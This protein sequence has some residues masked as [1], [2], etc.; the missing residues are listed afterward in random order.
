MSFLKSLINRLKSRQESE[1]EENQTLTRA[2]KRNMVRPIYKRAM[3]DRKIAIRES[4]RN[5]N[6]LC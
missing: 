6:T 2:A 3:R 1:V 4:R 5:N